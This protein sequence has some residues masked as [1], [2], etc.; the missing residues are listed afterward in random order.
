MEI[1][2]KIISIVVDK[3]INRGVVR[4]VAYGTTYRKCSNSYYQPFYQ[5]DTLVYKSVASPY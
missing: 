2:K 1:Q 3:S 4:V 5:G